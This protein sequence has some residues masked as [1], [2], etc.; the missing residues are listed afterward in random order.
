MIWCI[1]YPSGGFGHYV[2]GIISLY[3]PGFARPNNESIEFSSLG[4][5]HQLPLVAPKYIHDKDYYNY[6]FDPAYNYSVLI[7]NGIN[8]QSE[9]FKQLFPDSKII[10][11]VYDDW[12]WPIVAKTSIIK[13]IGEEISTHLHPEPGNWDNIHEPWVQREKFFLYLRD[14]EFRNKWHPSNDCVNIDVMEI[15]D[16]TKLH[17]ILTSLLGAVSDFS[18]LHINWQQAN[19]EYFDLVFQAKDVL[20]S[21][22]DNRDMDLSH[23]DDLWEQAV[24]NYFIWLEYSYEIP[25]NDFADWFTNTRQIYELL[26]HNAQ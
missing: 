23:I 8:N 19:K 9:K 3:A 2:N 10:K 15:H 25:I 13:A 11:I 7:D 22:K 5:S 21:L 6:E 24:I 14:G 12:S 4:N 16:Y 26:Q 17:L 1:W 20:K 18:D